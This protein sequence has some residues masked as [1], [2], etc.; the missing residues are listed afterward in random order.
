[1]N[2]KTPRC[3]TAKNGDLSILCT[4]RCLIGYFIDFIPYDGLCIKDD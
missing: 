3:S 4:L 1:M 2:E